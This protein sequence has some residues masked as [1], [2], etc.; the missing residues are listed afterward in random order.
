MD[1]KVNYLL[2]YKD[3]CFVLNFLYNFKENFNEKTC[4]VISGSKNHFKIILNNF[5]LNK[6]CKILFCIINNNNHWTFLTIL[7]KDIYEFFYFDSF[8]KILNSDYYDIITYNIKNKF[9]FVHNIKRLQND[10]YSCGYYCM[11]FI[12]IFDIIINKQNTFSIKYLYNFI[13]NYFLKDYFEYFLNK[14]KKIFIKNINNK[15]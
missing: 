6:N 4:F 14:Y 7:K 2:T 8:G 13:N 10:N 9:T 11:F 1:K 5:F 12:I 3:I 15:E